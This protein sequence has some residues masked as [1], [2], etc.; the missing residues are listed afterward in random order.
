VT[1]RTDI[2][3]AAREAANRSLGLKGEQ[4]VLN[5]EKA[6]LIKVGR[7]KLADRI[8]HTSVEQGD[9]VGF[10]IRS[11]EESGK[12]RLIEVKTT[13]YSRHTPF[14]MS[15]NELAVSSAEAQRYYLYRL[16]RFGR[17]IGLFTLS[18][19][20]EGRFAMAPTQY[21]VSI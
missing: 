7:E 8:E 10:D 12:D 18:G 19:R 13:R 17:E 2:D 20:L 21:R 11:F 4:F 3:Y 16:F 6:R 9:G 14:Y 5:F 1:P 15:S